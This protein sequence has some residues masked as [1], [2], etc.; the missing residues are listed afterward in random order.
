MCPQAPFN[1]KELEHRIG[2]LLS[3]LVFV[4]VA[5]ESVN[6]LM[7]EFCTGRDED[8]EPKAVRL[9]INSPV[10]LDLSIVDMRPEE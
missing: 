3:G 2:E 4:R 10:A 7:L 1:Q 9:Y 5:H 8:L 6:E